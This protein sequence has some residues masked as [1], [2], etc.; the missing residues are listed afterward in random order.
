MRSVLASGNAHKLTEVPR[1]L[2]SPHDVE[3]MPA[4]IELPP[5]GVTSFEDNARGKAEALA[6]A[7]SPA[8]T[9]PRERRGLRPA[10]RWPG[11]R[12]RRAPE[13]AKMPPRERGRGRAAF[14]WSSPT[15]R[16]S[17]WRAGRA[18]AAGVT[19]AR[20]AGREGDDAANN[21]RLFA[22]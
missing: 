6:G 22:D 20:Y 19:S 10:R 14:S 21:R 5:E 11:P 8:W 1:D 12:H 16:V 2:L 13:R 3:P 17:R 15:I 7:R 18:G 4:G 9:A